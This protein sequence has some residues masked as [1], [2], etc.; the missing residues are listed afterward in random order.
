MKINV[1]RNKCTALGNCEAVT[2][3]YFQV[4]DDGELDILRH[5]VPPQKL[6]DVERAVVA[7]PMSALFISQ[8]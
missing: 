2:P 4:N 1:N 8:N 3:E 7:C 5:D 6:A